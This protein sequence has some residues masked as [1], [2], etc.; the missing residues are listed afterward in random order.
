MT[1]QFWIH[2]QYF[3]CTCCI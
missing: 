2:S 3:H 1:K